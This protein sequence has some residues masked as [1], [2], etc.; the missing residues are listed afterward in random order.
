MLDWSSDSSGLLALDSILSSFLSSLSMAEH[1]DGLL[2]VV[3]ELEV[4]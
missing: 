3:V 2:A 1:E 4:M